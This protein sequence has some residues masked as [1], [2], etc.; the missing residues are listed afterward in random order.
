MRSGLMARVHAGLAPGA[1]LAAMRVLALLCVLVAVPGCGLFRWT[2]GVPSTEGP[3]PVAFADEATLVDF[4]E[5]SGSVLRQRVANRGTLLGPGEDW[6]EEQRVL[7]EPAALFPATAPEV[8][9]AQE[10]LGVGGAVWVTRLRGL[11]RAVWRDEGLVAAPPVPMPTGADD[12]PDAEALGLLGLGDSRVAAVLRNGCGGFTLAR[13][14]RADG[15]AVLEGMLRVCGRLVGQPWTAR[16]RGEVLVYASFD[17]LG[18][19]KVPVLLP[20]VETSRHAAR[21]LYRLGPVY[22]PLEREA[23]VL[24]RTLLRCDATLQACSSHSWVSPRAQ[25]EGLWVDA[26]RFVL[27]FSTPDRSTLLMAPLAGGP[28]RFA[29]APRGAFALGGLSGGRLALLRGESRWH[30]PSGR[31]PLFLEI[32]DAGGRATAGMPLPAPTTG[33][34]D[35]WSWAFHGPWLVY[36]PTRTCNVCDADTPRVFVTPL[37]GGPVEVQPLTSSV[38]AVHFIGEEA[39][40][41][42]SDDM[43]RRLVIRRPLTRPGP[44]REDPHGV[45]K[46]G[47]NEGHEQAQLTLSLRLGE[48]RLLVVPYWPDQLRVLELTPDGVTLLGHLRASPQPERRRYEGYDNDDRLTATA[49]GDRLLLRMPYEL[50]LLEHDGAGLRELS[51]LPL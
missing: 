14:A 13:Y 24:L 25:N 36:G 11:V 49:W 43:S 45:W 47:S 28:P 15:P 9:L 16:V 51:R 8:E 2:P 10:V 44:W 31:K 23:N 6:L 1:P 29:H 7:Q 30:W 5:D 32:L 38:D 17:V 3:E 22:Y 37:P 12:R 27:A 19:D 20:T 21:S 46:L 39:V 4:L 26:E 50:V 34:L 33:K 35:G 18:D 41:I 48:R 40:L 42:G